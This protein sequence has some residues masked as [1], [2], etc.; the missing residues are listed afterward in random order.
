MKEYEYSFKV[1]DLKPYIDY[2]E[3]EKFIKIK[4]VKQT[5]D[6]YTNDSGVLARVT[7]SKE[8]NIENIEI[9]FKDED[10]S[11]KILKNTRESLP[12]NL[13]KKNLKAFYTILDI[14][15]YSQKK[16]LTRTRYVYS[17]GTVKFEIDKYT[18]PE[19]MNVVAIEGDKSQV[20]K[21]Y[22]EVSILTKQGD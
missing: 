21:I 17:K 14:L 5:R 2:C 16:H 6:L 9:D 15:G 22:N 19:K 11:N 20:D 18:S 13:D 1:I 4:E 10:D 12:L 7:I 3:K 8:N